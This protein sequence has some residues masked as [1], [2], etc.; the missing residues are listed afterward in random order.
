MGCQMTFGEN[1]M[2][3]PGANFQVIEAAN[4]EMGPAFLGRVQVSAPQELVSA[5]ATP[6]DDIL[7]S[8]EIND[9]LVIT[10]ESAIEFYSASSGRLIL[11]VDQVQAGDELEICLGYG[12]ES[13][14]CYQGILKEREPSQAVSAPIE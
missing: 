8:L 3:I 4:I 12:A 11:F 7:V 9:E 5:L 10:D 13:L 2:Q 6:I 1:Q 14:S